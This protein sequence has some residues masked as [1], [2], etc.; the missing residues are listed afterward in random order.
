MNCLKLPD[1]SL[2]VL[3]PFASLASASN[4]ETWQA[5]P[6]SSEWRPERQKFFWKLTGASELSFTLITDTW[7]LTDG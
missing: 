5:Q 6:T 2:F 3:C 4:T 7:V 1:C